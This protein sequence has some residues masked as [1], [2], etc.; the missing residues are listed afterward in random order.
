MAFF[1]IFM[2]FNVVVD[3]DDDEKGI[4]HCNMLKN[5]F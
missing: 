1:S 3:D 2:C 4:I 5:S